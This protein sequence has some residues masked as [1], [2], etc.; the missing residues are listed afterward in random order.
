MSG[1]SQNNSDEFYKNKVKELNIK[2]ENL[3][4]DYKKKILNF[5]ND[6]EKRLEN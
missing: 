6:L 2:I 3:E 5:V 4:I 1:K